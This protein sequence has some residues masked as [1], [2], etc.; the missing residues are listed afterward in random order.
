MPRDLKLLLLVDR[1]YSEISLFHWVQ[2]RFGPFPNFFKVSSPTEWE[3]ELFKIQLILK[4]VS[5]R[6]L[7]YFVVSLDLVLG[8]KMHDE[9]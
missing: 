3:T 5:A 4:N 9:I 6:K 7:N 2:A 8:W 1:W